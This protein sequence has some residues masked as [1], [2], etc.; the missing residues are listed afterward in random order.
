MNHFFQIQKEQAPMLTLFWH[1]SLLA[2]MLIL[3]VFSYKYYS[4]QRFV[5][6]FQFLQILQLISLYS[7]YSW[8]HFP[9]GESLPLYHCR[10]CMFAMLLLPTGKIKQYLALLGI[11][12]VTMALIYPVMDAYQFPHLTIF[13]YVIGH[14][15]LLVNC[16]VYL[17]KHYDSSALTLRQI[18]GWTF[19]LNLFLIFANVLTKG[20]YGMLMDPPLI[21]GHLLWL[22]YLVISLVLVTVICL[23]NG[24][25]GQLFERT[26]ENITVEK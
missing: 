8:G 3:I 6:F 23:L 13:S 11:G 20:N 26:R 21:S 16:L 1:V 12:G 4:N 22:N 14:Y 17:L 5:R 7:W 15:A 24:L 18:A 25:F 9:L 2:V 19:G 10:I